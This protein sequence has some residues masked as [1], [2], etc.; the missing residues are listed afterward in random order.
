MSQTNVNVPGSSSDGMGAGMIVGLI[1]AVIIVAF[2]IWWFALGGGGNGTTPGDSA[3]GL[4]SL[5]ESLAPL[6]SGS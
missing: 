4:Q 6:P 2:L 5:V 3:G 1:L